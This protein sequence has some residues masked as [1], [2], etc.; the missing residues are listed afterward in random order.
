LWGGGDDLD[1]DSIGPVSYNCGLLERGCT[2]KICVESIPSEGLHLS[3]ELSPTEWDLED[4]GCCLLE[5]VHIVL[6]AVKHGETEVYISGALSAKIQ[7]ECSRC[8]KAIPLPIQS[9]F[10]LE[11]LPAPTAFSAGEAALSPDA[12]DLNY[13]EGEEIDL[14][15]EM[16]GQCLLAIPMHALCQPDCQG[17]CP[18]CGEDL[19]E[20]NCQCRFEP[21]DMRWAALKNFKYKEA[22]AKSKT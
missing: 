10:H 18:H 11:Y 9:D 15:H 22:D 1:L 17:L 7:V 3:Y 21:L 14:D 16:M 12:L 13:Y 4:K 19:N 8:V 5:P 6:D 2:V 20:V